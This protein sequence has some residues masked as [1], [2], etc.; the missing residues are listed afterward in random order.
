MME[1]GRLE[2]ARA[3][4]QQARAQA[5]GAPPPAWIQTGLGLLELGQASQALEAF[6]KASLAGPD[7]PAPPL[8]ASLALLRLGRLD[9]ARQALQEAARLC[10]DNQALPTVRALLD[11]EAGRLEEALAFLDPPGRR[12]DLAVSPPVISRLAVAVERRLLPLEVPPEASPPAPTPSPASPPA[13][14]RAGPFRS[15]RAWRQ[16]KKGLALISRAVRSPAQERRALLEEALAHLQEGRDLD[17]SLF[18]AEFYLGEARLF[19]AEASPDLEEKRSLARLAEAHLEA[20]LGAEGPNP[21]VH[22]YLAR[23]CFLQGRLAEALDYYRQVVSRF[24][25]FPEAHYGTG[26]CLLLLGRED[27]A[28]RAF[29]RA[30]GSDPHLLRE[31]IR[32]LGW[33]WRSDPESLR[34]MAVPAPPPEPALAEDERA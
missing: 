8:F 32:E 2:E 16:Q 34:R 25:K 22:Y 13:P 10:P 6:E 31:R 33:L 30:V 14:P 23:A 29:Y 3:L 18:R 19:L 9:E 20:A 28:R 21:Y 7:N 24:E 27:E 12:P 26:Q 17:P 1:R 15:L 11:L 5:E 4:L